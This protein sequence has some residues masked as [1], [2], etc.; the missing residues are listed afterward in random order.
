MCI[1]RPVPGLV[2]CRPGPR[3]VRPGLL[4]F[5]L[6]ALCEV[7]CLRLAGLRGRLATCGGLVTRLPTF[8]N[9]RRAPVATRCAGYHPAP[10]SPPGVT[11]FREPQW[12]FSIGPE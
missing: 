6:R 3:A 10:P 1:F 4:S 12:L 5:A 7:C 8:A 2:N 11:G 9:G